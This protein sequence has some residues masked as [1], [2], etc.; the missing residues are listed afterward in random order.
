MINLF[1]ALNSN[2]V[3]QFGIE[4]VKFY[5]WE[6]WHGEWMAIYENRK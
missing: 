1:K 2:Y 4:R 5:Q 6:F 3:N